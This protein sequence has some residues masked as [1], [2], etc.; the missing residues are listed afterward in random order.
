M[1]VASAFLP[2]VRRGPGHSLHGHALVDAV[3]ALGN[4]LPGVHGASLTV[5]WYLV[6]AFGALTWVALGLSRRAVTPIA[7]AALAVT[8]LVV[9][10]FGRAVGFGDLGSGPLLAIIGATVA[11]AGAVIRA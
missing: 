1:L 10:A 11:T 3:L 7:I 4:N 9:V 6:P 2:W 5:F 8:A